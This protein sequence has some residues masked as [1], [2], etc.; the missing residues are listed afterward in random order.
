M[1]ELRKPLTENK[2][3]VMPMGKLL[4]SM[5]F[6]MMVSMLVQALYNIVDSVFV[7]RLCENALTAVSLAFP[8]QILLIALGTG[9]GVGLNAVLSKALGEKDQDTVNKSAA[10][11]IF[12][13]A[14][15]GILFFI[16][17]LCFSRIFF[18][19]Q[20]D[21]T[22]I[23]EYGT[24]YMSIC[25]MLSFG[26]YFQILAERLL[27]ATG[28]T[29][30]AMVTQIIGAVT[31][32]ILDPI[33]IFGLFGFPRMEV[34]GA[35]LATVCGQILAGIIGLI[36]NVKYNKDVHL[37]FKGFRPDWKIIAQIYKVGFPS[38]VMQAV[39]SVMNYFMNLILLSFTST[40]AAVFGAYYKLQSFFFMPLFGLNNA[41]VPIVA[42]NYGAGKRSRVIKVIKL[43]I[44]MAM[45]MMFCGLSIFHAVPDKLLLLFDASENMI[46]IGSKALRI[47]SISYVFA[48]FCIVSGSVFQALG[49]GVYSLINSVAR[50]LVV[51]LPAAYLLSLTGK[52]DL[53]WWSFPI[54]EI[55]S[56]TMS[57]YLLSRINKQII[58]RIPDNI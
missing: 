28:R 31:N 17:G 41:M 58:S 4:V 22:Q 27:Q 1:N 20:T 43:S 7:G 12:L 24:Q 35:A 38:I 8:V 46:A 36:L 3:G 6:P 40:A 23:L 51:L 15:C 11:G 54:A 10:N 5:A 44:I 18:A 50:Q 21:D 56:L 33:M 30:L 52:L 26:V 19:S 29:V 39:G 16:I 53:V 55:M 37:S 9:T 48:G 42:Y 34:A 32:I 45:C 13:A 57:A 14:C 2:M 49:N 25:C 47:I